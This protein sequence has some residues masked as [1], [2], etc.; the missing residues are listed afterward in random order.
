MISLYE[1]KLID[2]SS[3]SSETW[4]VILIAF[5][6]LWLGTITIFTGR[7]LFSKPFD[8]FNKEIF[9]MDL[10]LDKGRILKIFLLI[11]SIIGIVSGIQHW[12]VLIHKYGSIPDVLLHSY[13]IYH[14]R[15]EGQTGA[16]VPYLWLFSYFGVMLGAVY[17]AY[18]GKITFLSILP[19]IGVIIK[20]FA[21]F[22][23]GGILFGLFEFT[24]CFFL[25]RNLLAKDLQNFYLIRKKNIII[26]VVLIFSLA[27]LGA[28]LVKII[29]NPTDTFQGTSYSLSQ[30]QGNLFISP[31]IYFYASSQV[32]VL[33]KYLEK[34][35]T[36]NM[37]F[38][39]YTFFSVYSVL[40]NFGFVK[41]IDYESKGYFIPYWSNTGTFLRNI[42]S[43]FGY[44]GIALIPYLLGL[45]STFLWFKF[46]EDKK[47]IYFIFLVHL[48][49]I[50][51]MSFFVLITSMPAWS[52][53]L[54]FLP[55]VFIIIEKLNRF[56]VKV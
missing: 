55:I 20:E 12:M 26:A 10:F 48:Y 35:G 46:Y 22:T 24:I 17:S 9:K 43:D 7:Y 27:A 23:R 41:K 14:E 25:F 28:S 38:G 15:L 13:K 32:G 56:F 1:L 33:N 45:F 47:L 50:I 53:G 21:R 19:L 8:S 37:P 54:I 52:F 51:S 6:S 18:K 30:Y 5:S 40:S 49:L 39:A 42:H 4:A 44:T 11:F 29:R 31:S 3:L 2:F 16:V 34:E 36:E